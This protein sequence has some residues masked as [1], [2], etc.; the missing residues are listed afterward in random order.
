VGAKQRLRSVGIVRPPAGKWE[1]ACLP[2]L[3]DIFYT[4]EPAHIYQEGRRWR[5]ATY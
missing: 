3:A 4:I 5:V 1:C 2:V